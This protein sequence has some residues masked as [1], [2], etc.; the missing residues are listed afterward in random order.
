MHNEDMDEGPGID[1]PI[2]H[3]VNTNVYSVTNKL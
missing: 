1:T 2:L 3:N